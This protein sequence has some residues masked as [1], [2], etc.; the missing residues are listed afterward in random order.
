MNLGIPLDE[1]IGD[2]SFPAIAPASK[3]EAKLKT[4]LQFHT[5]PPATRERERVLSHG[6]LGQPVV[7]RSSC[8]MCMQRQKMF[9]CAKQCSKI[10][11]LGFKTG[12]KRRRSHD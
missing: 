3:R 1:T 7:W 12:L 5:F 9:K 6:Q 11:P 4:T 8:R 10:T 2:V